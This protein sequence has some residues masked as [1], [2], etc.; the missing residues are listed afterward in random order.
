MVFEPATEAHFEWDHWGLLRKR[1]TYV[2]A[3]RVLQERN[4][5]HVTAGEGNDIQDTIPAVKGLVHVDRETKQVL[6][7]TLE[8]VDLPQGF[9]VK[10]ASD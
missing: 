7:I 10:E 4:K 9:P 6:R 5:W 2:F 8:A 1:D 3:Y